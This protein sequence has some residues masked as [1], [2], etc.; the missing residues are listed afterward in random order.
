MKGHQVKNQGVEDVCTDME[1]GVFPWHTTSR[2]PHRQVKAAYTSR[3]LGKLQEGFE[4]GA[5]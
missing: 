1:E 4:D 2:Q 3:E 5:I